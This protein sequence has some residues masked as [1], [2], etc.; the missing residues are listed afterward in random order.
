VDFSLGKSKGKKEK[1][2]PSES[3]EKPTGVKVKGKVTKANE[4]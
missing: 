2:R 1:V 3:N 4:R